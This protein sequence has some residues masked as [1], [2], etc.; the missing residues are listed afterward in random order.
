[1]LMKTQT[2]RFIFYILVFIAFHIYLPGSVLH[3]QGWQW[4]TAGIGNGKNTPNAIAVDA[5]GYSYTTGSF[6]AGINFGN[7]NINAGGSKN[8]FLTRHNPDG[9]L[10]WAIKMNSIYSEAWDVRVDNAGYVYTVGS[11][12]TSVT[13]DTL[14]LSTA[15]NSDVGYLAKLNTAGEVQWAYTPDGKARIWSVDV[16]ATGNVYIAGSYLDSLFIGTDTLLGFPVYEN[17][18]MA[19]FDPNGN[20]LWSTSGG[21][22][23]GTDRGTNVRV[24]ANGEIYL[25]GRFENNTFLSGLALNGPGSNVNIFLAKYSQ[26]GTVQWV[27]YVA[28][29]STDDNMSLA[30]DPT[31]SEAA[32]AWCYGQKY[33]ANIHLTGNIASTQ[34]FGQ[35]Y[36]MRNKMMAFDPAGNLYLCG[37]FYGTQN[38]GTL[39]YGGPSSNVFV[40]KMD[41]N[42]TH[43]WAVAA[44]GTGFRSGRA[45]AVDQSGN[46]YVAG[47]F[48]GTSFFESVQLVNQYYWDVFIAKVLS[49]PNHISGMTF[50]DFNNNGSQDPGEP[51]FPGVIIEVQPGNLFVTTDSAGEYIANTDSGAFSLSIPVPP[52]YHTAMPAAHNAVFNAY[53]DTDSLNNFALYA[54]F[55]INDLR[56]T[57]TPMGGFRPGFAA[58]YRLTYQNVGTDTLD[59]SVSFVYDDTLQLTGATPPQDQTFGD[60]LVW[61]FTNLAPG[62][63][64]SIT[65]CFDISATTPLGYPLT[66]S[67]WVNPIPGDQDPID[68][69]DHANHWVTGS[70]DPNDKMVT[71]AGDLS[72]TDIAN[73]IWLTYQI[74]FQNTGNDTA[75][76]VRI[77][78]SLSANLNIPT[79]DM[80]SASHPYIYEMFG[81][82]VIRW[83]FNNILLPDSTTNEAESHG[84]VKFRIKPL[85][86]IQVGDS[87]AN[88]AYIYFDFNGPILTNWVWNA[89]D[90][91]NGVV[92]AIMGNKNELKIYPN[93]TKDRFVID[94]SGEGGATQPNQNFNSPLSSS[95][96]NMYDLSGRLV[97]SQEIESFNSHQPSQIEV[98][99]PGLTPGIYL[100]G[101]GSAEKTSWGKVVIGE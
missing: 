89:V 77:V 94:F 100:I 31:N 44:T 71:P 85:P 65:V 93:P 36:G 75:F 74:R 67:A 35:A 21:S 53:G 63:Q 88:Q 1:M 69:E 79:F 48:A 51:P 99:C 15:E 78:D 91:A 5:S 58:C 54:P 76:T 4:A 28:N 45:L 27:K 84:F 34:Q 25:Q 92:G 19:K 59:G 9:T 68:N 40:M 80:L 29:T 11:F 17:I 26:T 2:S 10:N 38:F 66:A 57:L 61:F 42:G 6:E 24:A 7:G 8:A 70:Y 97:H 32:I 16:D 87:I 46:V 98:N 96:L 13:I 12:L 41:T 20:F 60:S 62:A 39:I 22:D 82:G 83:T 33:F 52:I 49:N 86:G 56:I 55:G 95:V 14:T 43:E 3:A 47:E 64:A 18:F 23:F 72:P 101:L 50:R 81:Q 30:I 90:L 73:G 37:F